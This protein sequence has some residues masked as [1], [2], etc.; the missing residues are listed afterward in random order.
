MLCVGAWQSRVMNPKYGCGVAHRA[1]CLTDAQR[2]RTPFAGFCAVSD[3][4]P[5]PLRLQF[6]TVMSTKS[7]EGNGLNASF[8]ETF[9]MICAEP[10]CTLL[11]VSVTDG[12]QE[13]AYGMGV[14][15]DMLPGYRVIS[16][17]SMFGT[18]I[19]LCYLLVWISFGTEPNLW[20]A[21]R[22]QVLM[23]KNQSFQLTKQRMQIDELLTKLKT[24]QS[25]PSLSSV[26]STSSL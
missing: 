22:H 7:V 5:I 2:N 4:L 21:P 20:Y 3:T 1:E 14:V 12:G 23:M 6:E 11:R 24:Q 26:N 25:A 19:E 10:D 16:L 18:R 9:H 13:V 17:R 15:N 8:D